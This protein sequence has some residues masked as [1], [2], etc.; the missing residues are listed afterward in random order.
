MESSLWNC[1][2]TCTGLEI[3]IAGELEEK[4]KLKNLLNDRLRNFQTPKKLEKA[5]LEPFR[6]TH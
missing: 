6:V 4:E 3:P 2:H 1:G 5:N